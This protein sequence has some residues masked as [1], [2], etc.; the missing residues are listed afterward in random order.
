[1]Q[2]IDVGPVPSEESCAQVGSSTYPEVSRRECQVFCR[3]LSRHFP[4]PADVPVSYVTREH[5]HE[6]GVYREVAIRFD[7]TNAAAVDLA[8]QVEGST[9]TEWDGIAHYELAWFERK[10]AYAEAVREKRMR[11]EEVPSH[12]GSATPPSFEGGSTF[13]ELL[14]AHPL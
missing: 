14:S 8:H 9:P 12:F 4:V 6:F 7:G 10:R 11:P 1:M 2:Y 13:A 3:M 5:Q